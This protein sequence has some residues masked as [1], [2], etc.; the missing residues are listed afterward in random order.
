MW[1]FMIRYKIRHVR[2]KKHTNLV[3]K[4][5]FKKTSSSDWEVTRDKKRR[6]SRIQKRVTFRFYF[7][8]IFFFFFLWFLLFRKKIRSLRCV[9]EKKKINHRIIQ[10]IEFWVSELRRIL[11]FYIIFSFFFY[12]KIISL[13]LYSLN[14][15]NTC[16]SIRLIVLALL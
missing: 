1:A 14:V 13:I 12:L 16:P 5:C 6:W 8:S 11:R 2:W 15:S 3:E 4:S 9:H 7:F 10:F